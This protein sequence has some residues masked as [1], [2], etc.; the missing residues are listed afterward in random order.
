[1]ETKMLMAQMTVNRRLG[2]IH[3]SCGPE[4]RRWWYWALLVLFGCHWGF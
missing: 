4:G 2:L 3:A 1:M